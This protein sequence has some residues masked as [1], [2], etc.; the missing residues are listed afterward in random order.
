M[1]GDGGEGELGLCVNKTK[2]V[3]EFLAENREQMRIS[4]EVGVFQ[5]EAPAIED[6]WCL[7]FRGPHS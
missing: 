4:A 3:W 5:R 6:R 1:T 7:T 2:Y